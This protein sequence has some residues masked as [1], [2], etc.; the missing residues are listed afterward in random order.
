[1]G[2]MDVTFFYVSHEYPETFFSLH[3]C[4][5]YARLIEKYINF[6]RKIIKRAQDNT[7]KQLSKCTVYLVGDVRWTEID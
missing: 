3:H 7:E 2:W 5:S 6:M 4:P 1:M